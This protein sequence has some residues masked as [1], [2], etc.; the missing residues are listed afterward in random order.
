[1][2]SPALPY[3]WQIIAAGPIASNAL[4]PAPM[5]LGWAWTYPSGLARPEG[6]ERTPPTFVIEGIEE[7]VEVLLAA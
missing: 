1:M 3:V 2:G 6:F 5:P 4:T 7:L